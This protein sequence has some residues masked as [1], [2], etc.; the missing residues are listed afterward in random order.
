[1]RPE[2]ERQFRELLEQHDREFLRT[3]TRAGMQAMDERAFDTRFHEHVKTTVAPVMARL[4]ALM[5]DH[6]LQS[7]LVIGERRVDADG[8]IT[9]S[10]VT[11]EFRVLTDPETHGFPNTTPTLAF[12]ADPATGMVLVQEN[13]F[14]PFLGGHVGVIDR[15]PLD[16]LTAEAVETHL[17]AIA[18]KVLRGTGAS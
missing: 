7:G 5:H 11:F 13:S 18:R 4:R 10:S 12:V 17:L 2:T 8:R 3:T 9:P 16:G 14:L 15:I 1:M 6:G